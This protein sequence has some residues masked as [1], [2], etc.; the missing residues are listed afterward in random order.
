MN[1]L[2]RLHTA[3]ETSET[4]LPHTRSTSE[5]SSIPINKASKVQANV[6]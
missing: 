2:T 3:L 1:A 4:I 5:G 6:E